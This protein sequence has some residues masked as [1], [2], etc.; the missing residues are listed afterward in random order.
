MRKSLDERAKKAVNAENQQA[1][2]AQDPVLFVPVD[3]PHAADYPVCCL[4]GPPAPPDAPFVVKCGANSALLEWSN[5][6]FDGIPPTHYKVFMRNN[7]RL[8]YNWSVVPGAE[9]LPH[10]GA[11]GAPNRFNV[12]HLPSGVA[13]EF[14]VA[15][16]NSGGWG[17]LSRPSVLVTPGD[18]LQPQSLQREWKK[19]MKG[20][21]LAVLDRLSNCHEN[22]SE[23]I[24]GMKLLIVFAQKEGVG[25][26]RI[27]IR[28]KV[29]EMCL[30]ALK[31]FPVDNEICA[32]AFNLIG[33]CIHGH[34]HKKLKMTIIKAGLIDELTKCMA[35]YRTDS[36]VINAV[37]WLR[38]VMPNDVPK[39][40]EIV[41]IPFG[42]EKKEEDEL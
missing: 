21:P 5:P 16:F 2:S 22:R 35:V 14:C 34:M 37:N 28:E 7:C 33:Y 1:Q 8:Y 6:P 26:S 4:C 11:A 18:F 17:V 32:P 15:A 30:R 29:A 13:V 27:N 38:R 25:F 10:A 39:N 24:T 40:G 3:N 9:F 36:K 42:T 20:G 23:H 41:I 19:V 12:N 31:M